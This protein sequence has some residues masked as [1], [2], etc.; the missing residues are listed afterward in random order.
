MLSAGGWVQ[1]A[2]DG[3]VGKGGSAFPPR[4]FLVAGF[5]LLA[6]FW[7]GQGA[8]PSNGLSAIKIA[9]SLILLCSICCFAL[10]VLVTRAT[11]ISDK[12]SYFLLTMLMAWLTLTILRGFSLDSEKL[13]TLVANPLLGGI[14]WLLPLG[15]LIGRRPGSLQA[16]M[17]TF[18]MH[19]VVGVLLAAWA[20][21]DIRI[22]GNTD[23]FYFFQYSLFLLYAAPIVLLTGI[24]KPGDA[25]LYIFSLLMEA[26][27]HLALSNR[28]PFALALVFLLAYIGL[29]GIR[30]YRFVGFRLAILALIALAI[31]FVFSEYF[32]QV[33]GNAWVQD[34]R[35]FLYKEMADDFS[36][37]DWLFGRGALGT[38]YSPYF[39]YVAEHGLVGDSPVRQ[40]NE[41]GYLHIILK[42]GIVGAVLYFLIFT[43][44]A[45]KA[46]ALRNRFGVGVFLLLSIHL[47][48][49][50]VIGQAVFKPYR[51]VLWILLGIV[52]TQSWQQSRGQK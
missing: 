37:L 10:D 8:F 50:T 48:E 43:R 30:D 4:P 42:A 14:V 22:I 1:S 49:L 7:I 41:I 16:L 23:R 9:V 15:I 11:P 27:A 40:V 52:F 20:I 29:N 6:I 26:G 33:L 3:A 45:R 44:G 46:L 17:P 24:G 25:P 21:I 36:G 2:Q 19:T 28:A 34:T 18:R 38:Y 35:T 31:T 12:S 5:Q 47:I 32:L 39:R 13:F 51:V